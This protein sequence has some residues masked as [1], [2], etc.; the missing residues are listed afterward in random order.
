MTYDE[1][2]RVRSDYRGFGLVVY[3]FSKGSVIAVGEDRNTLDK[4][5]E[6]SVYDLS[7]EDVVILCCDQH[8]YL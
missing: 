8:D 3:S 7:D 5:L 6:D 4:Q 2:Q 1:L